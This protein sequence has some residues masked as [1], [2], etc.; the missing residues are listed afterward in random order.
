MI[1]LLIV[2]SIYSLRSIDA[3][4]HTSIVLNLYSFTSE[5]IGVF[6]SIGWAMEFHQSI[7]QIFNIDKTLSLFYMP[8]VGHGLALHPL[9]YFYIIAKANILFFLYIIFI[10]FSF[11]YILL[12]IFAKFIGNLSIF[13]ILINVIQFFRNGPDIFLKSFITQSLFIL[14]IIILPTILLKI[15]KDKCE[16]IN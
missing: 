6:S 8:F 16:N 1:G 12:K 7:H 10:Y 5:F 4:S 13:I 14:S 11:V 2:I 3:N 15:K 9:A